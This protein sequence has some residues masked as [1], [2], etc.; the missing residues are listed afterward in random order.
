[1]KL[2]LSAADANLGRAHVLA[3]AVREGGAIA[4]PGLDK[5]VASRLE[6]LRASIRFNGKDGKSVVAPAPQ[7]LGRLVLFLGV[8]RRRDLLEMARRLAGTALG[9]CSEV[10]AT[11]LVVVPPEATQASAEAVVEGL[12]LADYKFDRHKTGDAKAKPAKKEGDVVAGIVLAAPIG[13]ALKSSL[14]RLAALSEG[15]KLARDLGNE[16]SNVLTPARLAAAAQEL[17]RDRRGAGVT[18]KVLGPAEIEKLGMGAFLGVAKGSREEPRFIHLTY[19]PKGARGGTRVAVVGKG[20]CF[21]SGGISIKP[22]A[23]MEDMKFDMC[24]AA[25]VLGL[26]RCLPDLGLPHEVHGYVAATE[27]M[28]GG[29]AIKPGDILRSMSGRTIEVLNTDAEGRLTL[30]DAITYALRDEPEVIVDLATLTGACV[31][32]LGA[33]SGIMSNDAGLR[34]AL[35]RSSDATGERAWPLPLFEDYKSQLKSDYADVKNLGERGGG[36]LTA[37]LFIQEWV[38]EG[39]PWAHLDIAGSGWA[40]RDGAYTRKGATGVGVRTLAHWLATL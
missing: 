1:M 33:A 38:P 17:A 36:A 15:V 16:P 2:S 3:V 19:K 5:R 27:N 18:C 35:W 22:A 31:I 11:R 4:A 34:D 40:D 24:G 23:G 32:A 14:P 21:D 7:G 30:V 28:P 29:A 25:A 20:L 26:F 13:K 12:L 6:S 10:S 9:K 8:G 39:L 37:G